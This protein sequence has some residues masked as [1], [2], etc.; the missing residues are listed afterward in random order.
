MKFTLLFTLL[1]SGKFY[2]TAQTTASFGNV[3]YV[4]PANWSLTDNSSYRTYSTINNSSNIFCIISIY[5]SDVS[6]GNAEGDFRNEWKGI[7]SGHFTVLKTPKP[8]RG[9]S[10]N[11]IAYLQDEANVSNAKGNFYARLLVFNLNGNVQSVLFLSGNKNSLSQY[12]PDLDNF[13][14]SV[15]P[16]NMQNKNVSDTILPVVTENNNTS[17]S[18]IEKDGN[19]FNHIFFNVPPAWKLQTQPTFVAMTAPDLSSGEALSL[20]LLAPNPDAGFEQAAETTISEMAAGLGGQPSHE[21]SGTGSFYVKE[22]EGSYLKGW[23]YSKGHAII[24]SKNGKD[25]LGLDQLVTWYMCVFLAK[26]NSRIER[27]VFIS[28]DVR[29]NFLNCRTYLKPEYDPI[30]KNFFF[31]LEFDDWKNKDVRPGKITHSGVSGVWQGLAYFE[32]SEGQTFSGGSEKTTYLAFFD[33]GQVYYNK[34]LPKNGFLHINSFNEAA[35]FPRW[36]GTYTYQSG[37]G[38]I[39]LSYET[40]PFTFKDGKIYLDIYKTKIPYEPSPVHDGLRLNGTWCEQSVSNGKRACISFT[41]D[42]QFTDNGITLRI[43]H[44]IDNC[45]QA[46]PQSGQGTYE[47]KDNSV[48]FH[49]NN[50]F[51][52]QAAFSGLNMQTGN[53]SPGEIHLGFNDDSFQ[54]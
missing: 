49:Y 31:D 35:N 54:K 41:G 11:G 50:G 40:I 30:I 37:S 20:I 4:E 29:R 15:K 25:A 45:F 24:I 1:V 38:V 13:I 44:P 3:S 8:N 43:E 36:W 16:G 42:G 21:I 7:V 10:T 34:Q 5:G 46:A 28:K 2:C 47:I 12:E 26:I 19:H 52:H 27:A 48:L 22:S 14:A 32:G 17:P 51:V 18:S 6:S 53:Q 39:K 9:S 33:N 23:Q